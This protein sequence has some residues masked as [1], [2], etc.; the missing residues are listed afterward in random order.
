MKEITVQDL[1]QKI[2]SGDDFVL[3]DVRDLFETHISKIEPYVL[4]PVDQLPARLDELD[5][6]S[7]TVVLC[8][9]GARS[10][11]ACELMVKDGF[12]NVANLKGGINE[13]AKEIDTSLPVY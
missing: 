4:I 10:A 11:R 3:L 6:E 1:K 8:R 13:W 2:D 7:E 5:K 9:S 12:K